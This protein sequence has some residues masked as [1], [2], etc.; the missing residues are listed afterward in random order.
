MDISSKGESE[1]NREPVNPINSGNV[2]KR[3]FSVIRAIILDKLAEGRKTINQIASQTGINWR[4][5]ELH[6]TFL[7]G[8]GAVR[9]VFSSQYVRIFE[10]TDKGLSHLSELKQEVLKNLQ[11]TSEEKSGVS[12][13]YSGDNVNENVNALFEQKQ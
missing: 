13:D 9:E 5:V 6:L 3:T 4:T 10:I 11:A 12:S 1:V 7:A 2:R 8:K